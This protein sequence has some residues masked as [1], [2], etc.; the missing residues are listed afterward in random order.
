MHYELCFHW[1]A[2]GGERIQEMRTGG[3]LYDGLFFIN[4]LG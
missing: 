1:K 4:R 3:V 2:L